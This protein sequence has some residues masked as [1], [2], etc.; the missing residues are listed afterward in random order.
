[1]RTLG[2]GICGNALECGDAFVIR[3]NI[4][5]IMDIVTSEQLVGFAVSFGT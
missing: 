4:V 3:L 2:W 1:M 5:A